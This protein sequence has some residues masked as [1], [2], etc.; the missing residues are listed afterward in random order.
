MNTLQ[1]QKSRSKNPMSEYLLKLQLI[2]SNTE[3]KN[4]AEARKY[5]TVESKLNG[6][7]YCRAKNKTIY[8]SLMNMTAEWSTPFCWIL[9]IHPMKHTK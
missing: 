2:V 7:K 1:S 6:E 4:M 5:E 9:D 3:F 8:L